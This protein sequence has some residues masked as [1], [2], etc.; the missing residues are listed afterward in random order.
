MLVVVPFTLGAPTLLPVQ[1]PVTSLRQAVVGPAREFLR[2]T[3]VNQ[4]PWVLL[5][6]LLYRWP[7]GLLAALSIVFLKQA[8]F[9][10]AQIGLLDGGWAIAATMIGTVIGGL[11]FAR[12]GMNRCLWLFALVG[13]A[14]NL[15]YAALAH[16]GGGLPGL[17]AAVSLENISSGMVGAGFVALLMS[18]CNPRFSATQYALLSGIYAFS[19]T[20]LALPSGWLA[21]Q[22]GWSTYF[23]ATALAALPAFLLMA[24]LVPWNGDGCRGAFDPLRDAT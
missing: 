1:H 4:A 11:L 9:S 12:L 6:V 18:L 8:G 22:V 23:L 16:F 2:R 10:D 7:D 5:L 3:G 20:L 19:R 14:G 24:K 13:A 15:G 17:M 21:A